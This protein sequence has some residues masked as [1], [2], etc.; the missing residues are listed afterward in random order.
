MRNGFSFNGRHTSEFAGITVR[1]KDRPVFPSV[2]E[3][4]YNADEMN[5]EYDF[6]DVSGHE[7]FNTRNF[8]IDFGIKA[9]NLNQL[10]KKLSALSR[11]FKGRGMLIFDDVPLVK[12]NVRIVDSVSY[13]PEN[14]GTKA[15]LSVTYKAMPFSELVFDVIEGPCLDDEIEL[16][17]EIPLDAEE[18]LTFS[19][20][21][22]YTN[23]PNVG[24]VH[25]KPVITV[26]GAT[27]AVRVANNGVSITV[28]H[29]GDFVIDCEKEQV[30]S[31][32]TSLMNKTT[33]EFFELAPGT[34]NTLIIAG[35]ATIQINYTPKFLYDVDTDNMDWGDE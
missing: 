28:T 6:S 34:D 33:G 18:Y 14:N 35:N 13:K 30:Y 7:Y 16:D 27:G 1:T 19:G 9:D 31:G 26:T 23:V 8:Q 25:V 2:K 24:D 15:I 12:W 10:Q 4:V 20:T 11:W 32:N 3:S 21:G 5:G 29:S 22:T 17:S